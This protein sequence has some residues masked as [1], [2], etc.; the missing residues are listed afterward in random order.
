MVLC[1]VHFSQH[2]KPN[3]E[4]FSTF[5]SAKDRSRARVADQRHKGEELQSSKGDAVNACQ[6]EEKWCCKRLSGY[7]SNLVDHSRSYYRFLAN[8]AF[9]SSCGIGGESACAFGPWNSKANQIHFW[10]RYILAPRDSS[11][12]LAGQTPA[13]DPIAPTTSGLCPGAKR[14]FHLQVLSD[15]SLDS[16]F[17]EVV[18]GGSISVAIYYLGNQQNWSTRVFEAS[19]YVHVNRSAVPHLWISKGI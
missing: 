2:N 5:L 11:N 6:L 12:P 1:D 3:L 9:T 17:G 14:P 8:R 18:L 16:R 13:Y 15:P 19:V 7:K 10:D 4:S